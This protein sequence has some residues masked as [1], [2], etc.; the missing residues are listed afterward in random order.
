MEPA[1][2][3]AAV[4]DAPVHQQ[5]TAVGGLVAGN[6]STAAA[7]AG[8]HATAAAGA[9][10]Y[11]AVQPSNVFQNTIPC[12]LLA[13]AVTRVLAARQQEQLDGIISPE[14]SSIDLSCGTALGHGA[15]ANSARSSDSSIGSAAAQAVAGSVVSAALPADVGGGACQVRTVIPMPAWQL[16]QSHALQCAAHSMTELGSNSSNYHGSNCSSPVSSLVLSG[17]NARAAA[18]LSPRQVFPSPP[19][20]P[21]LSD[22]E[23]SCTPDLGSAAQQSQTAVSVVTKSWLNQTIEPPVVMLPGRSEVSVA[24]VAPAV[25]AGSGTSSAELSPRLAELQS[26]EP[27][28]LPVNG[29]TVSVRSRSATAAAADADAELPAAP[30]SSSCSSSG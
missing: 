29:S 21:G 13:E 27:A 23:V 10:P 30:P 22:V 7:A 12:G 2:A 25:A 18:A 8:D 14:C 11:A 19:P 16:P 6:P 24:P 17:D 9:V 15:D 3:I 20:Q 5:F 28:L 26:L 4:L 1:A